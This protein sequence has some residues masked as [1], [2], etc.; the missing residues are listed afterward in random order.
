VTNQKQ[1]PSILVVQV[2]PKLQL[3]SCGLG[4]SIEVGESQSRV[5]KPFPLDCIVNSAEARHLILIAASTEGQ[6]SL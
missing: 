3:A 6:C 1:K 2:G 4:Y 5:V